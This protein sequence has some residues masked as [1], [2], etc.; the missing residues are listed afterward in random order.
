[1]VDR[2]SEVGLQIYVK[3]RE[4]DSLTE[5]PFAMW[6]QPIGPTRLSWTQ[7]GSYYAMEKS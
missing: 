7:V 6:Q 4:R 1:M 2:D 3:K 5:S